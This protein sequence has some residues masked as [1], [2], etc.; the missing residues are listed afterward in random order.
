M[1][2]DDSAHSAFGFYGSWREFAP[3]ALTNL[4]LTIVTLGIYRFWG[5]TRVRRYLWSRTRFID[6][7]LEWLGTGKELFFGFLLVLVLMGLPFLF[8]NFGLQSLVL[9]GYAGVAA[10]M[11]FAATVWIYYLVGLARFRAVR[12]RLS[13]TWWHGIRGGSNDGGFGYGL[14][15]L[16]KYLV[17]YMAFG[18]L[19]PWAM[20]SLWNERWNKMSFGGHDFVCRAEAGP[21]FKRFLLFYLAPFLFLLV[22]FAA[23]ATVGGAI[24][25]VYL[26]NNFPPGLAIIAF[27]VVLVGAY[28]IFGLI[29]LGYYS[30]FLRQGVGGLHLEG[31]NFEF[32]AGTDDWLKLFFGDVALVVLTLGIGFIFLDYRHWKF[33][34]THM[35]AY[36]TIDLE[37]LTQSATP[38]PGHGEGLLDALDVGAF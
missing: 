33:F 9:R 5:T 35:E 30:A 16:W 27:I 2:Q 3:I 32:A 14:S 13:R 19:I 18:L 1:H 34:I 7:R 25:N 4:L 20:I 28:V 37:R 11:G 12:Y 26:Y 29:A 24:G 22:G 15:Y 17:G 23:I 6:D 8:L 38:Q 21:I 10:A 31:L 36:G